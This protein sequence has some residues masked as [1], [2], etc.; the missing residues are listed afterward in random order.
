MAKAEKVQVE[1]VKPVQETVYVITLSKD[2]AFTLRHILSKVG[3]SPYTS[4]RKYADA[5]YSAL[6]A[7]GIPVP[8]LGAAGDDAKGNIIYGDSE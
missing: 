2:E 4:R 1:V 7:A 3:G 6:G 5:I 8:G